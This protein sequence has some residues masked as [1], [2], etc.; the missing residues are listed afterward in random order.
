M[1]Q[2]TNH[3]AKTDSEFLLDFVL[4]CGRNILKPKNSRY[5]CTFSNSH[6]LESLALASSFSVLVIETTLS[7]TS[8]TWVFI[9]LALNFFIVFSLGVW[10]YWPRWLCPRFHLCWSYF[11]S[12][13]TQH[14]SSPDFVL[15]PSMPHLHST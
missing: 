13:A 11:A 1:Q 14:S 2:F 4:G 10:S 7:S 3:S 9:A 6:A 12:P 5:Y 8:I 15:S